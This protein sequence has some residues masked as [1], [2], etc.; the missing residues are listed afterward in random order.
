[1][2]QIC[3]LIILT[4]DADCRRE[5]TSWK[6]GEPPQTG[7]DITSVSMA[8]REKRRLLVSGSRPCEE[9]KGDGERERERD[10][11]RER[12]TERKSVGNPLGDA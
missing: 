4:P 9:R 10:K 3:T 11:E 5:G 2:V 6:S 8:M 7:T 12:E 1:M